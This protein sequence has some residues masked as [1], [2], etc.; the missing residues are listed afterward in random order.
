MAGLVYVGGGPLA[1]AQTI[2]SYVKN[3]EGAGRLAT[4]PIVAGPGWAGGALNMGGRQ[5]KMHQLLLRNLL[6]NIDPESSG[7]DMIMIPDGDSKTLEALTGLVY[8]GEST[9]NKKNR[10]LLNNVLWCCGY[11]FGESF[12]MPVMRWEQ[13]KVATALPPEILSSPLSTSGGLMCQ[14]TPR[15]RLASGKAGLASRPV[16][17]VVASLR[18]SGH[19]AVPKVTLPAEMRGNGDSPDMVVI[20]VVLAEDALQQGRCWQRPVAGTTGSP[21][22]TWSRRRRGRRRRRRRG[23]GWWSAGSSQPSERRTRWLEKRSEIL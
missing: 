4:M 19:Y 11:S 14:K 10:G 5:C 9:T 6:P 15:P 3:C 8:N 7:V 16:H 2:G 17:T 13:V 21:W 23:R 1:A 12:D 22:K 18:T 20:D